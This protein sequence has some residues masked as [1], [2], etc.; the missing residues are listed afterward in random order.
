MRTKYY[1]SACAV[2]CTLLFLFKLGEQYTAVLLATNL[3]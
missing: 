3:L 2:P 1:I